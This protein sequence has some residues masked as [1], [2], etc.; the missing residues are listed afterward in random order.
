MQARLR[1]R[2]MAAYDMS[3]VVMASIGVAGG[4]ADRLYSNAS[5]LLSLRNKRVPKDYC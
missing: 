3:A 2:K 4:A 5:L 1:V